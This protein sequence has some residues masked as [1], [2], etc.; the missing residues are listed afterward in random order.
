MCE[1][2]RMSYNYKYSII[3]YCHVFLLP[4]SLGDFVLRLVMSA[5]LC[6]PADSTSISTDLT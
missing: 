6:Y 3:L 5:L 4:V 2:M 1:I